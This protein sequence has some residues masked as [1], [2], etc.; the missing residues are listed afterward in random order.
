MDLEIKKGADKT[1]IVL[2]KEKILGNE[3]VE[4]QNTILDQIEGGS[5]KLAIDL[6]KVNYITSWGVG[7]LIYAHTTC[8]NRNVDF[9]LSQ[10]N[11]SVLDILKKVKLHEIFDIETSN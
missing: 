6:G 4:F 1:I 5:K 11:N 9:S 3:A 8:K 7:I 10:V 2:N